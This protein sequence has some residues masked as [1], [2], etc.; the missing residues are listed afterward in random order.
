MRDALR[1]EEITKLLEAL[2]KTSTGVRDVALATFLLNTGMRITET[3]MLRVVD[4]WDY[5]AGEP[6]EEITIRRETAKRK[7]ERFM[8]LN[9]SAREAVRTAIQLAREDMEIGGTI[10][11]N[12]P[13]WRGTHKSPD[14]KYH[15]MKKRNFQQIIQNARTAAGLPYVITSHSFR[16][17]F[18]TAIMR[19]THD[20]QL[21]A[22]LA[23][24]ADLSTTLRYSHRSRGEKALAVEE[25]NI[26]P[27]EMTIRATTEDGK[28]IQITPELIKLL[29]EK[30]AI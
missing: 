1:P 11:A 28:I 19:G 4:V 23:G 20:I 9:R 6:L 25:L 18:I 27:S 30:K 10:P 17:T 21:A 29:E 8:P 24:H 15:R 3:L 2:G 12:M 5:R 22:D 7:K 14:G 16:H 13:L 26:I